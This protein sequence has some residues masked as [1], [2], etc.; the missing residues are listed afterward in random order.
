MKATGF[1]IN[2]GTL[3]A[4][5]TQLSR[6]VS[7]RATLPVLSHVRAEVDGDA[8]TLS[9]TDLDESASV[10]LNG[11]GDGK[12]ALCLHMGQLRAAISSAI[13]QQIEIRLNGS[14][15]VK[16]EGGLWK[17]SYKVP[18]MAA[19]EFP[20]L[21]TPKDLA[22]VPAK[23][24]LDAYRDLV[25]FMSTDETRHV[26]NGVFV[27]PTGRGES[28]AVATDGRRLAAVKIAEVEVPK[29]TLKRSAFLRLHNADDNARLAYSDAKSLAYITSGNWCLTCKTID[30]TYPNW[31]Q[32]LP[33]VADKWLS[34][35]ADLADTIARI[36][37][38]SKP[39]HMR[40]EGVR[41][42]TVLKFKGKAGEC[43]AEVEVGKEVASAGFL[44]AVNVRFFVEGLRFG[45]N[46]YTAPDEYAP[47]RGDCNG[48]TYV[49]MPMR[50]T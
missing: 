46:H 50:I 26:L 24:F 39:E 1:L 43:E 19:D 47:L 12:G 29:L 30:G 11:A 45:V 7:T 42:K 5:C 4:A 18:S 37:G 8:L 31:R 21:P 38:A 6:L 48:K 17:A 22:T 40:I 15:T 27:E 10:R 34:V 9:T 41:G 32:V 35:D 16:H 2:T 20:P 36:H 23:A 49:L 13:G 28:I 3:K 14:A 25:P 33:N 44:S